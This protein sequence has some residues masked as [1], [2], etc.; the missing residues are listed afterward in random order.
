MYTLY[1]ER[2]T[3]THNVLRV[4]GRHLQSVPDQSRDVD[5]ESLERAHLYTV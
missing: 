2:I 1:A 5:D 4:L 3:I